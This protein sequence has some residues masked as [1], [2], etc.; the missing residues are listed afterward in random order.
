MISQAGAAQT[1]L[2]V[3]VQRTDI[4]LGSTIQLAR[5]TYV[6]APSSIFS[7]GEPSLIL[8]LRTGFFLI[9]S[10]MTSCTNDSGALVLID[11]A[12]AWERET[13]YPA[14]RSAELE[15]G[16]AAEARR[17]EADVHVFRE[18]R[19]TRAEETRDF[20]RRKVKHVG[21]FLRH[22]DRSAR[23]R[24]RFPERLTSRATLT[25]PLIRAQVE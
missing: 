14:L 22:P 10:R 7:A 16:S 17:P 1:R 4:S 13:L 25:M 12:A 8:S 21:Q 23:T 6:C 3:Y 19:T 5:G 20:G 9:N 24:P 18:R 2:R 11:P 15:N